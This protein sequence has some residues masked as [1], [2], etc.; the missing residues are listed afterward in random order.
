ML[1]V[2][3]LETHE[4]IFARFTSEYVP[5]VNSDDFCQK[6]CRGKDSQIY[7]LQKKGAVCRQRNRMNMQVGE[8]L[9]YILTIILDSAHS[10]IWANLLNGDCPIH[11]NTVQDKC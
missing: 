10:E 1:L 2:A 11:R 4:A 6:I 8:R 5:E 3:T 7:P 9:G